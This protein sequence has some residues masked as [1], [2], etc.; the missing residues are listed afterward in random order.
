MIGRREEVRALRLLVAEDE[1][2][3]AA[4]LERGLTHAGFTVDVAADGSRALE[5][6]TSVGYDAIVLDIMLPSMSG[7]EV[8]RQLRARGVWTP[9]LLAS[10]KDGEYDQ[11]DGLDLGA[12]DYLTKPFSFVV[13]LA[14][15]RALLRRGSRP[16]PPLIEVGALAFDPS[17]RVF[18]VAGSPLDL[19]ARESAMLEY[20]MRQH[21]RAVTKTELLEHVWPDAATDPNAVEVYAGYLRRKL[22]RAALQTVRGVGYRLRPP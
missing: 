7:Y 3:M 15:L 12:D 8:T 18:A 1:E 9:I 20:L 2:R 11:A 4:A 19:T 13:L 14:R 17:S 21:P 10:A 16:R 22:G 6:A 5:L